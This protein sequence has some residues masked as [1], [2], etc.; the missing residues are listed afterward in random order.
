MY[1]IKIRF[2]TM[3]DSYDASRIYEVSLSKYKNLGLM[4]KNQM[5][6]RLRKDGIFTLDMQKRVDAIETSDLMR[7]PPL[8]K[9]D[10]QDQENRYIE[11]CII[12]ITKGERIYDLEQIYE[13]L[14]SIEELKEYRELIN[15]KYTY[16]Q[17]TYESLAEK[18]KIDRLLVGCC[19]NA[20]TDEKLWNTLED[21]KISTQTYFIMSLTGKVLDFISGFNQTVL[22]NIS[23]NHMW[24]TRWVSASKIGN[25]LFKGEIIDWDTNKVLL[26]YWS[27]LLDNVYG[28]SEVPEEFILKNDRLLDSWLEAKSRERKNGNTPEVEGK[29]TV[30]AIFNGVKVNP[31]K[32]KVNEVTEEE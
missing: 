24:R 8:P 15:L 18:D 23:R 11:R 5:S 6:S 3:E 2:P 13:P 32:K 4:S 7:Y 25:P 31:H 30:R 9:F 28:G 1:K 14:P 16:L 17:Y 29:D 12:E 21:L 19:Y 10:S 22:R 20:D 26:C 27:N